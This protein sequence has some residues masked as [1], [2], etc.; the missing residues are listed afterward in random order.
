[1]AVHDFRQ[2]A[3]SLELLADVVAD[4]TDAAARGR[5]AG[6]MREVAA[7]LRAMVEGMT[8]VARLEAGDIKPVLEAVPLMRAVEA[9]LAAAGQS[10]G[11]VEVA[12]IPG[13][14]R[15]DAA[16]LEAALR[17]LLVYAIH[18]GRPG[19]ARLE[20]GEASRWVHV[21]VSFEGQHPD[22]VDTGPAFVELAAC[23]GRR[24]ITVLA[25]AMVQR[26]ITAMGGD[27]VVASHAD[28][29]ASVVLEL[30]T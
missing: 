16:L 17:G 24:P 10:A 9:A 23:D 8:L 1:M 5:V 22:H 4:A 11:Q 15:A 7:S 13:L 19:T 2:P 27:V 30:P 21:T 25:P 6:M 18:H 3:Q 12:S 28:G 20:G 29:R 26:L 14:V